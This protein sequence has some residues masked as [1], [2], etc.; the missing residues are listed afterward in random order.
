MKLAVVIG[1]AAIASFLLA[2]G[3]TAL[4]QSETGLKH[5]LPL[6]TPASG[7]ARQVIVRIINHSTRAG[8]VRIHA[9]DDSGRRF[10]PISLDLAAKASAH[11]SSA[12]L[13]SGNPAKGLSGGVGDGEGS[14][15]L[16]LETTLNIEPLAYMQTGDGFLTS[17]HDTV[18][19][20][21][22]GSTRYHVPTFNPGDNRSQVSWL[23]L[24]NATG[25]STG[26]EIHGIDDR[27]RRSGNVRVVLPSGGARTL[28]APELE[29]GGSGLSGRLGDGTGRWQLFVSAERPVHLMNLLRSPAGHLTNL[30]TSPSPHRFVD[31]GTRLSAGYVVHLHGP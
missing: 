23:R 31:A 7:T 24:I 18:P 30:S 13:E 21:G 27:G 5:T 28:G 29:S 17:M 15:R 9:I 20:S 1:R 12:D 6:V 26:V 2:L 10:G 25:T 8:T 14:W 3:H 16:E 22:S 11:F 19:G 4:A